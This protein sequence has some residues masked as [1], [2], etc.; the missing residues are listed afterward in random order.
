MA[1]AALAAF[2]PWS[3]YLSH[4]ASTRLVTY[5][6]TTGLV[7]SLS[8]LIAVIIGT[9][10][11]WIISRYEFV[12]RSTLEWAVALPL[13]IPAYA[14][15]Y[16]WYDLTQAAGPLGPV[17]PTLRGPIGVG[18]ILGITLYPYVYLLA[19]QAFSGQSADAF[20][21]ARTLGAKPA[22]A[23]WRVA[24]P[25]A[26]PAIAAGLALVV[27]ESLADYGAAAHLGAPTLS[28]GL[29]RAGQEKEP[30]QMRRV[31]Q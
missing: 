28:V 6:V 23:F 12:G 27:M 19:R 9:A 26:R 1:V 22:S 11:A 29:I 15:A 5:L 21:A 4:I 16:A 25:M 18:F 14:A 2:G 24:L 20:E 3:D 7:T 10:L 30:A 31:W 13:A 8:A 17:F